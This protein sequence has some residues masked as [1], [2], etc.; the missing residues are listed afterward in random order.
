MQLRV[1]LVATTML[2]IFATAAPAAATVVENTELGSIAPG[3]TTTDSTGT[4]STNAS[5]A[6]LGGEALAGDQWQQQN[7]RG[8]GVVGITTDYADANGGNGSIYFST[9]GSGPSKAD[10]EYRFSQPLL[11]S[12]FTGGSYDWFR[13]S[14]STINPA[15]A[16][17]YRLMLETAL[18][19]YAGYLVFEP[20]L[21]G[22]P[23][24]EDAWQ[25]TT[26]DTTNSLF[27]SNKVIVA[28]PSPCSDPLRMAPSCLHSIS[29]WSTFNPGYKVTGFSTGVG[30]GWS[31][32]TF[33]GAVDNFS[34]SFGSSTSNFDFEVS[35]V[36]E[37]ATWAMMISGF[38]L[39]GASLRR[40]RTAALAA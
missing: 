27:W 6:T 34:Y 22:A 26:I 33:V 19:A 29:D 35:A 4:R 39:A 31:P 12:D 18:G 21:Q 28:L 15:P 25:T 13:D 1:M 30:S 11:L 17:S 24:I 40:R 37:P 2:A 8:N 3:S 14:A 36:P 5:G 10:M 38:G 23:P 20:Y 16:P 9:D 32:G 7:V